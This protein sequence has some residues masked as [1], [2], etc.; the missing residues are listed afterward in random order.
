M[1]L[2][3]VAQYI[4]F[5]LTTSGHVIAWGLVFDDEEGEL[6]AE[7]AGSR[8]QVPLR[9]GER[10]VK[11]CGGSL[12]NEL[13]MATDAGRLLTLSGTGWR[14]RP[15]PAESEDLFS[16]PD[17]VEDEDDYED[18]EDDYGEESEWEEDWEDPPAEV[19]LQKLDDVEE[20]V[21]NVRALAKGT[22]HPQE[23]LDPTFGGFCVRGRK[24]CLDGTL[25]WQGRS[26]A[27]RCC[28]TAMRC[29]CTPRR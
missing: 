1:H 4:T 29:S 5:V 28:G 16:Q 22:T 18:L 10:V 12:C 17:S 27:S 2:M 9:E 7:L 26:R 21:K 24:A 19:E 20:L 11:L 14:E 23:Q 15:F 6:T 25:V 8:L 13:S 3:A